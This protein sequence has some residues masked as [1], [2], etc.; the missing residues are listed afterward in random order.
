MGG[1]SV[2]EKLQND[3]L[4]QGGRLPMHGR[5]SKTQLHDIRPVVSAAAVFA[6]GL[7]AACTSEPNHS[8]DSAYFRVE[9]QKPK[10][11]FVIKLMDPAKIAQARAIVSGTETRKLGVMGTIV[12]SAAPYNAPWQF[13]L[14]PGSI[15]FF[16][17]AIEVCD[18][19]T[20]YV[21]QHL[22][23]V[24]GTVLPGSRWCPWGSHIVSEVHPSP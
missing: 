14:D 22:D 5:A 3:R 10:D 16:E 15:D 6:A 2:M 23:E 19:T 8:G 13:H 7:L 11:A 17:S 21:Q 9:M 4:Q 1:A 12:A 20:S 18:A 24:G